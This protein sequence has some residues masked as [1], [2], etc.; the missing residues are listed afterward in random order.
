MGK[1][2]GGQ[3]NIIG[4]EI[5]KISQIYK[6]CTYLTLNPCVPD[7]VSAEVGGGN[8][9]GPII[10]ERGVWLVLITTY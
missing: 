4:N 6:G 9:I 5:Y 1:G 7:S 2:T 10:Y 3:G 8:P